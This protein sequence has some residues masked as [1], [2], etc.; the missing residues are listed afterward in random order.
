MTG[1]SNT[2]TETGANPTTDSTS[3]QSQQV[4]SLSQGSLNS[5]SPD[6]Q[7][8]SDNIST[9]NKNI[10]ELTTVV[11]KMAT[12]ISE[13]IT[14]IESGKTLVSFASKESHVPQA[15]QVSSSYPS[16]GD[17]SPLSSPSE[18][19]EG[20]D[21][22]P[23]SQGRPPLTDA[24][25]SS[26]TEL[27]RSVHPAITHQQSP[28]RQPMS[29]LTRG[30]FRPMYSNSLM[31]MY[32]QERH[33]FLG[34]QPMHQPMRP[35]HFMYDYDIPDVPVLPVHFQSKLDPQSQQQVIR[36]SL[37][38]LVSAS[39]KGLTEAQAIS[40]LLGSPQS[41]KFFPRHLFHMSPHCPEG[42][43]Q[44]W[45]GP[46]GFGIVRYFTHYLQ[47]KKSLILN[48]LSNLV[49]EGSIVDDGG[50]Y[51]SN[52]MVKELPS[53]EDRP[54][55]LR[56]RQR[57]PRVASTNV[58][59]PSTIQPK[60]NAAVDK[61]LKVR[62]K[63]G[64]QGLVGYLLNYSNTQEFLQRHGLSKEDICVLEGKVTKKTCMQLVENALEQ[65]NNREPPK[66]VARSSP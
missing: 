11:N 13:I 43:P 39:L 41:L 30:G 60:V 66:K 16:D 8:L 28:F 5:P 65:M 38:G 20:D 54:V 53:D 33:P 59:E 22:R 55:R 35:D 58:I 18:E 21:S 42:F 25:R 32:Q 46:L 57:Y 45:C 19:R 40:A 14:K 17:P 37:L 2:N 29:D 52:S 27:L 4:H 49:E 36:L 7:V 56:P 51:K 61:I 64:Q 63:I 10:T 44:T 26:Q 3:V 23:S 50:F 47:N 34:Q 48:E 9:L 24:S 62:P 12:K 15:I 31:P 6:G 1:G